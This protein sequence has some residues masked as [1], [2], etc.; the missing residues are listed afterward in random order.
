MKDVYENIRKIREEQQLSQGEVAKRIG[1]DQPSYSLLERGGRRVTVELLMAL[2]KAFRVSVLRILG[3]EVTE[4]AVT[5][6]MVKY[7]KDALSQEQVEELNHLF[8]EFGSP[9]DVVKLLKLWQQSPEKYR[10]SAQVLLSQ[11]IEKE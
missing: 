7:L 10:E 11:G 8:R 2:S 1:M 3:E 6:E 4:D 9:E 5:G